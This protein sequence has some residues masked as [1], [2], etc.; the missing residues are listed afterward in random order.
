MF[1]LHSL[2]PTL[3]RNEGIFGIS[4]FGKAYFLLSIALSLFATYHW[5]FFE[6][7]T[8]SHTLLRLL[9]RSLGSVMLLLQCS[10]NSDVC[11]S[12]GIAALLRDP[13][14]QFSHYVWFTIESST[15]TP[16]IK[17]SGQEPLSMDEYDHQGDTYTTAELEKLRAYLQTPEGQT[18]LAKTK[19]K[20]IKQIIN[21]LTT[22]FV[23]FYYYH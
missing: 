7:G 3:D 5:K 12:L 1:I 9:L 15:H 11:A 17:Y 21:Y 4:W 14:L 8:F 23:F 19:R 18:K 6:E 20:Y 2:T 10:P 16:T 22:S 13:I